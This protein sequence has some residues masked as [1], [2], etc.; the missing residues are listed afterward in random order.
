MVRGFKI[1][2]TQWARQNIKNSHI[3]HRNYHE[4]IIR[5]DESLHRIR[6]YILDNPKNWNKKGGAIAPPPV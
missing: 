1:R 5:D 4:H 3:W 6:R 2:V